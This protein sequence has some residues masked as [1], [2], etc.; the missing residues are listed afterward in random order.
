[1]AT[2]DPGLCLSWDS[3][4]EQYHIP[5]HTYRFSMRS[6][7]VSEICLSHFMT[8]FSAATS[9]GPDSSNTRLITYKTMYSSEYTPYASSSMMVMMVVH[10]SSPAVNLSSRMKT[11]LTAKEISRPLSHMQR[12]RINTMFFCMSLQLQHRPYLVTFV[13]IFNNLH[14][15]HHLLKL[16]DFRFVTVLKRCRE[17][18]KHIMHCKVVITG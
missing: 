13:Q 1:M 9:T 14:M 17:K 3:S 8:E 2:S 15:L 12:D 16:N 5:A 4:M 7:E 11:R 10:N 18:N 6:L